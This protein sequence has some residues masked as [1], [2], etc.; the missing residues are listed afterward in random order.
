MTHDALVFPARG[1]DENAFS[2]FSMGEEET[3]KLDEAT[4]ASGELCRNLGDAVDQAAW[5]AGIR[6]TRTPRLS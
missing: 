3:K 5:L 2:G 6:M 4:G 1:S